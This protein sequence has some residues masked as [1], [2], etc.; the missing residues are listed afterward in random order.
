MKSERTIRL[1][2]F[3]NETDFYND[4]SSRRYHGAY[5]GRLAIHSEH[6]FKN[7]LALTERMGLQWQEEDSPYIVGM[8]MMFA[9][10]GY[11]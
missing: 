6:V 9:K 11:M 5:P 3:L 1:Q 2:N 4:P 10:S 7:L 8:G